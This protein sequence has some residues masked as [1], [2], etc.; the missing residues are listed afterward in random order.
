MSD[1]SYPSIITDLP[2]ARVPFPGVRGWLAST[3]THQVAF[4][5]LE[6]LGE[7]PEHT[8][9]EQWGIVVSGEMELTIDGQTRRLRAGDSYHIPADTPHSA[10]ILTRVKAIDIFADP[11]RYEVDG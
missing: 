8:H 11:R 1:Q 3:D 6:P 5:D 10:R 9:A 7:V 2:A 4:L